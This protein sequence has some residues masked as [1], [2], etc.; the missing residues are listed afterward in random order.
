MKGIPNTISELLEKKAV[1][2]ALGSKKNRSVR[3]AWG[4]GIK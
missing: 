2:T 4:Y 3:R 1:N